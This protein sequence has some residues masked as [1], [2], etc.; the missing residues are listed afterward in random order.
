MFVDVRVQGDAVS[1]FLLLLVVE[2][3]TGGGGVVALSPADLHVEVVSHDASRSLIARERH[4]VSR[5]LIF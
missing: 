3:D 1:S 5:A 2:V 4:L